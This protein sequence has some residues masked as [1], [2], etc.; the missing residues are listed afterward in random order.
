MMRSLLEAEAGWR[1][2]GE[3]VNGQEANVCLLTTKGK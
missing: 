1:V 2:C 3:G